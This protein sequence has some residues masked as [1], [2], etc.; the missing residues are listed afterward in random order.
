MLTT[1]L[2]E[3]EKKEKIQTQSMESERKIE[4]KSIRLYYFVI[5]D[6]PQSIR[7]LR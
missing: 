7:Y 2:I 3:Q 5:N 6:L 4:G 1:M